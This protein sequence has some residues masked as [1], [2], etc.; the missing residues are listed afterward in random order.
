MNIVLGFLSLIIILFVVFAPKT[1]TMNEK[2]R[3]ENESND[4]F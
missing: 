4:Y 3:R 1:L 2:L